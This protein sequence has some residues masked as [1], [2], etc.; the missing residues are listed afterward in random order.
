[1][2]A[3]QEKLTVYQAAQQLGI[4]ESAVRQRIHRKTLASGKDQNGR[5]VV[6]VTADDLQNNSDNIDT[7]QSSHDDSSALTSDYINTLKSQIESLQQ[8]I[9]ALQRDKEQ[10]QEESARKDTL[11]AQMNQTLAQLASRVPAIEAPAADQ[12]AD[13]EAR[14]SAVTASDEQSKGA[15]PQ[16]SAEGESKRSWL[17]RL[18]GG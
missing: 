11:L 13:S 6:Y 4:S 17:Q 14:E 8:Y 15:V 16:D 18:L 1:M 9:D 2:A 3:V 7:T 12:S 5:L 10:Y